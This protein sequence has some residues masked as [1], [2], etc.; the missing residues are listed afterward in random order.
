MELIPIASSSDG[1][2]TLI[3]SN[4]S[5]LLIDCGV[6]LR[7]LTSI[8]GQQAVRS[9]SA[10]LV[11][12]EHTDHIKGI[13]LLSRRF[14]HLPVYI[15][16]DSYHAKKTHF[17]AVNRHPFKAR[18][19]I[20]VDNF[21]ITPFPTHHDSRSS[22]GFFIEDHHS[23]LKLCFVADTGHICDDIKERASQA[24]IL[25]IECDYDE[26]MLAAF[27]GYSL[28]LKDRIAG[29][30]G[31]LSNRQALDL[32][33]EVGPERFQRIVLAHLSPR[34][35]SPDVVMKAVHERFGTTERFEVATHGKDEMELILR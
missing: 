27:P 4:G 17:F 30:H 25:F 19:E 2:A 1:N 20:K 15:H 23:R 12:H 29:N 7:M 14:P 5:S 21:D 6:S 9:L 35:N 22:H 3:R 8:V 31:H 26:E 32:I 33:E 34:T 18:K 13:P 10:L 28:D 24:D 11:T 16:D